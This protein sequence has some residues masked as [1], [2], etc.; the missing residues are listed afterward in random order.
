[1]TKLYVAITT[2]IFAAVALVHL[3]RLVQGWPVELGSNTIP[4]SVSWVGL[5]VAGAL[6]IW[7]AMLLRR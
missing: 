3:V 5:V 7:G 1:M 4:M 6:M 2:I